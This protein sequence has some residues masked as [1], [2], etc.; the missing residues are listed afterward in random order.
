MEVGALHS[1]HF[2]TGFLLYKLKLGGWLSPETPPT[3]RYCLYTPYFLT[4][5]PLFQLWHLFPRS[6]F[7]LHSIFH[8]HKVDVKLMKKLPLFILLKRA[9]FI[10][11]YFRLFLNIHRQNNYF[12]CSFHLAY[13]PKHATPFQATVRV[14][15]CQ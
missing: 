1:P 10:I 8:S 4:S 6:L 13:P 12:K 3:H 2:L 14:P 5:F 15:D 11:L 9:P 7:L